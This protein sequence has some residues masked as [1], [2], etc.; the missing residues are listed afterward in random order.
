[1]MMQTIFKPFN[2]ALLTLAAMSVLTFS[3]CKTGG[4]KGEISDAVETYLATSLGETEVYDFI[5]LTNRRD[6]AFM[7]ATLPCTGVIYKVTDSSTG[8]SELL[9]A[10]VILSE[11]YKRV[12]AF[13]EIGMDSVRRYVETKIDEGFKQAFKEIKKGSK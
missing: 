10:D 7:G 12:V 5:G 9:C 13:N 3:S 11:D 8:D 2:S 4:H 1:M 6:T